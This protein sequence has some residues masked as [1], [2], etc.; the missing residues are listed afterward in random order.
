MDDLVPGFYFISIFENGQLI[1]TKN[2]N[3]L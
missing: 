3:R 2:I 1:L